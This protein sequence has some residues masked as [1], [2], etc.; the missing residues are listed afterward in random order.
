MSVI[1]P[2]SNLVRRR[3][4]SGWSCLG[5]RSE[6]MTI[7]FWALWIVLNV[8]KN[9]SWTCSLPI[10][11]WMS[12]TRRMSASRYRFLNMF[13]RPSRTE[14]MKSFVNSSVETYLTFWSAYIRRE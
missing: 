2:H 3:S 1:R 7:C 9:S 13:C 12:S 5:G 10:R 8:W 4:S 6:E 14:L 11:N